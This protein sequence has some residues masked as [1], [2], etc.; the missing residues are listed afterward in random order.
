MFDIQILA[1]NI[2]RYRKS[3]N[4]TQRDLAKALFV[5]AQSVSKWECGIAMPDLEKFCSLAETLHVSADQLLGTAEDDQCMIAV[6]GGG[7]KTEFVLFTK[8]GRVLNKIL[9]SG[10]NPNVCNLDESIGILKSGIDELLNENRS[11]SAI[12]IG[13]AGLASG[14]NKERILKNL[15]KSY[16]QIKINCDS[17]ISNV[18]A[19]VTNEN[20]CI[21]A[22]C[23]TGMV[24]YSSKNN[25]LQRIGGWGYLLDK[26]GSGYNIGCDA[27]TVALGE[28]DGTCEKSLITEMIEERLGGNTW[29]FITD[30]YRG[31]NSFIASFATLVCDA[32]KKG[33]K[34]AKEILE[35]NADC[36]AKLINYVADNIND[37]TTLVMAGSVIS[38]DENYR[39]LIKDKI[40]PDLKLYIP[41]LPPI[42]GACLK[43]CDMCGL[44]T[45]GIKENF[46]QTYYSTEFNVTDG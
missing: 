40:N 42:F 19:S 14:N 8:E 22:I 3:I 16:R 7:T 29:E 44:S 9:K 1:Q 34:K 26:G 25:E 21:A 24:I 17:D 36:F 38:K 35:R 41:S 5:S 4:L 23:G 43:C 37:T 28:R 11:V 15:S 31:G 2:K 12:Y 46:A 13:A 6:D 39:Q 33:D 30:I 10:C 32:Y 18:I 27:L 45:E 20:N